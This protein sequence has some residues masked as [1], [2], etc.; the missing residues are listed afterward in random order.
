MDG[1]KTIYPIH[2]TRLFLNRLIDCSWFLL[3]LLYIRGCWS[4]LRFERNVRAHLSTNIDIYIYERG[5]EIVC[6]RSWGEVS[7]GWRRDKQVWFEVSLSWVERDQ[8]R[9]KDREW[10]GA[11]KE[12]KETSGRGSP[13]CGIV[14]NRQDW[15]VVDWSL[16]FKIHKKSVFW[17]FWYMRVLVFE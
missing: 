4:S 15:V 3:G 14:Q 13:K 5:K 1:L 17:W 9:R 12:N 6:E 8:E 10:L 16:D 2:P 7:S 11:K